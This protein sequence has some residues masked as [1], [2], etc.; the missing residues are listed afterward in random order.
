AKD[1]QIQALYEQLQIKDTF[2][3]SLLEQAKN[4]QVLLQG[5]QLL[6]LPEKKRPFFKRL[7]SRSDDE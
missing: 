7:F 3:N 4:Y 2:I 5:Q 6:S 1:E